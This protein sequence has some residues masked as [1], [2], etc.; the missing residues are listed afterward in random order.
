MM[1]K[2]TGIQ[3]TLI[4]ALVALIGCG[5]NGS[6]AKVEDGTIN[7]QDEVVLEAVDQA[8]EISEK[9]LSD[10]AFRING[11]VLGTPNALVVLNEL[12]PQKIVFIDSV[13]TNE[14]GEFE[15]AVEA[16]KLRIG[17]ISINSNEPPG[18]PI[19][20][21][22]GE[23]VKIEIRMGQFIETVVKG[24]HHNTE[25]KKLYDIYMGH[26]VDNFKF[27]ERINSLDPRT[28]SDSL[29]RAINIEYEDLTKKSEAEIWKFIKE[30]PASAATYFASTYVIQ[31]PQM[32]ML[33]D[34]L[35]KLEK[36]Y[37]QEPLT[38]ELKK[39]LSQ[40]RP[41]E[42]GGLAPDIALENPDGE[43]VK[44]SSLRGKVVLIDFWASWC[45]PCRAENPN[46]KRVYEKYKD[47]GFAIYGVS[48]DR[49]KEQWKG[50]IAQDG[51]TWEHV[52]D[53][54][55]WQS[56]AAQLYKVSSIPKTFLLDQKGRVIAMDLRGPALENKLAEIFN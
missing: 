37:A 29:K 53:L 38:E 6:T 48:L 56:S 55:G 8:T 4:L 47:R 15:M 26:N 50:A 1:K 19:I 40:T 31:K 27:Q 32:S 7:T 12:T 23:K 33:D 52:S 49:K 13:R 36:N 9:P 46:V 35:A 3:I 14:K 20:L 44:L 43:I 54:K 41:L 51:L 25:M 10:K 21:E 11:K 34:A 22:N 5:N 45:R 39:R 18:V 24:G 28:V 16:E 30:S 42:V 17:Y 2:T